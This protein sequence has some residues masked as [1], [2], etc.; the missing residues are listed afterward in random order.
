MQVSPV[1]VLIVYG[2]ER[3]GT[4]GLANMI[5]T[6][7]TERGWEAQVRPAA[8]VEHLGDVDAVIVGGAVYLNRWHRDARA[9]VARHAEEL[10]RLPVWL[11]SS[12]PLDDSARAGNLAPV[13][14]VNALA[15]KL[16]VVGH[17]TF[18]GRLEQHPKGFVARRMARRMAGDWRD[19]GHVREWVHQIITDSRVAPISSEAVTDVA[20]LVPAQCER[21]GAAQR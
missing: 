16:E 6:A 11:F 13:P 20:A 4:A 7:F 18:G 15:R 8:Q 3:G 5:G 17:M 12:G 9:F 2:S 14:Q 10:K 21:R 19:A 1:L